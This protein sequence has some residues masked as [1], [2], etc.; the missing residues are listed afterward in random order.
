MS[1]LLL[2]TCTPSGDD[3]VERLRAVQRKD[4]KDVEDELKRI[5]HEKSHLK[6]KSHH[7]EQHEAELEKLKADLDRLKQEN[8]ITRER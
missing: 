1:S 5:E 3:A 4:E 6:E 7:D 2:D 8:K